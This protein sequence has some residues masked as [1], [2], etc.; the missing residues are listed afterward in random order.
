MSYAEVVTTPVSLFSSRTDS[1][2]TTAS[3]T[4]SVT[5]SNVVASDLGKA[6]TGTNI[7]A[8]SV[9]ATVNPGVGFT[10]S[11]APAS[12]TAGVTI[13]GLN[14][15]TKV[16]A[17]ATRTGFVRVYDPTLNG[18]TAAN[19]AN[20]PTVLACATNS[21]AGDVSGPANYDDAAPWYSDK[22]DTYPLTG[23]YRLHLQPVSGSP[24][25]SSVQ[26]ATVEASAV[27]I[28]ATGP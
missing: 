14:Y 26:V 28:T 25:A 9:V 2:I 17:I 15:G 7:S 24:D 13:S 21:V 4:T 20:L 1:S 16:R 22:T 23:T 11:V 19:S 8:G 27:L 10:L 12:G 18:T 6:V 5:D 3:S